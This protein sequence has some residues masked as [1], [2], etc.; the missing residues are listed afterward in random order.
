MKPTY[1]G[2]MCVDIANGAGKHAQGVGLQRVSRFAKV[3]SWARAGWKK[4]NSQMTFGLVRLHGRNCLRRW[5]YPY[6]VFDI[7]SVPAHLRYQPKIQKN[8]I[9][10]TRNRC[11]LGHKSHYRGNLSMQAYCSS[12]RSTHLTKELLQSEKLLCGN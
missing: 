12:L 8:S 6:Q 7:V 11:C 9:W 5:P 1:H 2:L 4:N 10:L 3:S